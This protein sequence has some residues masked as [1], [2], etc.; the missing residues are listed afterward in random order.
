VVLSG[1]REGQIR[2]LGPVLPARGTPEY[3]YFDLSDSFSRI[4]SRETHPYIEAVARMLLT[5]EALGLHG[6]P[7]V[8]SSDLPVLDK[9]LMHDPETSLP[10]DGSTQKNVFIAG[11]YLG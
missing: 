8:S 11:H 10:W 4:Y 3:S 9:G 5:I 7:V 6:V 2:L 1:T